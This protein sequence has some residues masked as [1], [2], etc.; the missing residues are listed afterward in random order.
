MVP[1]ITSG[2]LDSRSLSTPRTLISVQWN[3]DIAGTA[4][5]PLGR[6]VSLRISHVLFAQ[7]KPPV[8]HATESKPTD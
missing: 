3:E 1:T 4:R 7:S 2:S 8:A 5:A 6:Y